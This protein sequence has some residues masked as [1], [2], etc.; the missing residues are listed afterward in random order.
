MLSKLSRCM[1]PNCV[2]CLGNVCKQG[3]EETTLCDK[4]TNEFIKVAVKPPV[5]QCVSD[6]LGSVSAK[7]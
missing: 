4:F 1:E 2:F 5:L 3:C 6:L 7:K